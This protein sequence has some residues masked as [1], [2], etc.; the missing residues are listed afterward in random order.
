VTPGAGIL[1]VPLLASPEMHA[2]I[3]IDCFS[4]IL[5][6]SASHLPI[7]MDYTRTYRSR[8]HAHHPAL[9]RGTR[10]S[11]EMLLATV[12]PLRR[13]PGCC[14]NLRVSARSERQVA[15][16]GGKQLR[17]DGSVDDPNGRR[18]APSRWLWQRGRSND[19]EGNDGPAVDGKEA[20]EM[21]DHGFGKR[22]LG[23]SEDGQNGSGWGTRP[24]EESGTDFVSFETVERSSGRE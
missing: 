23:L 21:D 24:R 8:H 13:K 12:D 9:S 17:V 5:L 11:P 15:E 1:G 10:H 18:A 6:P 3:L 4:H 14:R 2:I 20:D 16:T 7:T 19:E 22:E